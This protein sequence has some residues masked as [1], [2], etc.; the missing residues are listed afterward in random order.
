[1][2]V[3]TILAQGCDPIAAKGD[4]IMLLAQPVT[5]FVSVVLAYGC[6]SQFPHYV[7][8]ASVG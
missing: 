3:V 8:Q 5:V 2:F 4:R 7:E 6:M 1:M